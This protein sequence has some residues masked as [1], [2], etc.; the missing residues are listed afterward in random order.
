MKQD[1]L[2]KTEFQTAPA[3]Q[4][5]LIILAIFFVAN[6]FE[7][8]QK[9]AIIVGFSFLFFGI[10]LAAFKQ[11]IFAT[12][13]LS[14]CI[15]FLLFSN[16]EETKIHFPKK[17]IQREN[18]IISGN[19]NKIIK[20]SDEQQRLV[21]S[22]WIDAKN[23]PRINKSGII[24]NI[25]GENFDKNIELGDKILA[26]G[27]I[28]VPNRKIFPTDFDEMQYS[29]GLDANFIG[30]IHNNYKIENNNKTEEIENSKNKSKK[31]SQKIIVTKKANDFYIAR[32]FVV[33]K[34]FNQIDK[35]FDEI[36]GGF[37]KSILM[38]DKSNLDS[39]I[40]TFFSISGVA[41]ILALSGL[42]IGIISGI[43]SIFLNVFQI[44]RLVKFLLFSIL[45]ILFT[46]LTGMQNATIRAGGMAIVF[47]FGFFLQRET[48]SLN[49]ISIVVI[50]S[51]IFFPSIIYS[52]GFQMSVLAVLGIFF[53]YPIFRNFFNKTIKLK[54][55]T[56][57]YFINSIS[58]TLSA[59]IIV[60]P[61]IA[62]YFNLF[63]IISPLAN[64][65]IIPLFSFALIFS[66]I[67]LIFSFIWFPIGEI[68]SY[69][70]EFI[71]KICI[72]ITKFASS[73]EY[74]AIQNHQNLLLI[75]ILSSIFIIYLFSSNQ[76]KQFIFR[77]FSCAILIP[78]IILLNNLVNEENKNSVK[79]YPKENYCLLSIPFKNNEKFVWIA[80]R[81]PTF[82]E[83]KHFDKGLIDFFENDNSIKYIGIS[84]NYGNS[85][86]EIYL[87]K[88]I[89]QNNYI[90]KKLSFEQQ[91]EIEK[92]YLCKKYISQIQ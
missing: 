55:Q 42:H 2:D 36:T 91:K 45:I 86:V 8:T 88:N 56:T 19:V 12:Y 44:N 85:F 9:I 83:I 17:I 70:V 27:K 64:L 73:F 89:K 18:A 79:I 67:S 10:M 43:L 22:G 23:L 87:N 78:L 61:I 13:I 33:N 35:L 3:F 40:K 90:I 4:I 26:I 28:R 76:A 53:F 77:L 57:R 16:S 74:S 71:L 66:I 34:T 54:N 92:L 51:I 24:L 25:Y 14:I 1:F 50:L 82:K 84:G 15:G 39:E 11:K 38:G 69:S 20:Q 7:I 81:K 65:L 48:N 63:S 47:M 68:L 46:F 29:L 41:H 30:T 21:I 6:Y 37:V 60:S 75:S 32:N 5:L 72:Q 62:M 49:I 80:D 58:M 31:H 52:I 59:S